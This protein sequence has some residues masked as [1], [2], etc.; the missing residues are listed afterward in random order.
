MFASLT[1]FRDIA[2]ISPLMSLF[3]VSQGGCISKL[4]DFIL[5]HLLIL[6]SVGLGIA[7]IQVNNSDINLANIFTPICIFC[8]IGD[9][10]L[11][12]FLSVPDCWDD[13]YLLPVS[14]SERGNIL[15]KKTLY[16]H[17][18]QIS[19]LLSVTVLFYCAVCHD[20]VTIMQ[21]D[22]SICLGC[23]TVVLERELYFVLF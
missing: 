4:E 7:F 5:Q 21:D 6:G 2:E 13:F 3:H 10:N 12:P 16:S 17:Q 23:R 1:I 18:H 11:L 9:F 19:L 22:R 20:Y 15:R 8:H 14:K